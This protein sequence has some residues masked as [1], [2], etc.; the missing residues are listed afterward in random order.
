MQ[1][2]N[3]VNPHSH[4]HHH[5]GHTHEHQQDYPK[6][7][8]RPTREQLAHINGWGADLDHKNRPAVPMERKPP[9][10]IP[11]PVD[12][13]PQQSENVE[14]LVSTERPGITPI[15]GTAQPPSGLSG[16]MR[17]VAFRWAENDRAT[18]CCC[19]RPTASTWSKA[20]PRTWPRARCR[21]C[22]ARWA[23][24]PSGSITRLGWSRKHSSPAPWAAR[25]LT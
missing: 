21:T 19:W 18:G 8:Q 3:E 4:Q 17:R 6:E 9:R 15:F 22:W 20:W 11:P 23:S 2:S 1:T 7:P 13:L 16:M 14:V 10:F 5:D 24:R 12:R 25:W